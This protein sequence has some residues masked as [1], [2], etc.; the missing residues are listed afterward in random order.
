MCMATE[1]VR[2]LAVQM[3]PQQPFSVGEP[4]LEQGIGRALE[5]RIAHRGPKMLSEGALGSG[6]VAG[7]K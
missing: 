6:G 2:V 1:F 4:A 7:Q 3:R 5:G